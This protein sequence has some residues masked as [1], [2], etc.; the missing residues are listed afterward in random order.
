MLLN[1][2]NLLQGIVFC[3]TPIN[4]T[5]TIDNADKATVDLLIKECPEIEKYFEENSNKKSIIH[6]MGNIIVF[7]Y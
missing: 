5:I 7:N 4:N 1:F 3:K 6:F 2:K